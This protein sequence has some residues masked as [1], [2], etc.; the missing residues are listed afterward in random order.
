[1]V[2]LLPVAQQ[3]LFTNR[4]PELILITL[5]PP[6]TAGYTSIR[7]SP[8]YPAI[9]GG[10]SVIRLG[11]G[12]ATGKRLT[13]RIPELSRV[14]L[15]LHG[16]AGYSGPDRYYGSTCH[17]LGV[18][19]SGDP[20][21]VFIIFLTSGNSLFFKKRVHGGREIRPHNHQLKSCRRRHVLRH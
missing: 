15:S 10:E 1:M 17:Q 19:I 8:E 14:P 4:L 2:N 6:G 5:S 21:R 12:W 11:S 13:N 20:G 7:S 3:R 16:T 9:P 18:R